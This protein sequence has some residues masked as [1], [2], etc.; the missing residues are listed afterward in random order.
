MIEIRELGDQED[1]GDDEAERETGSFT[2]A[3]MDE[4]EGERNE[5]EGERGKGNRIAPVELQQD[6]AVPERA[7]G[8]RPPARDLLDAVQLGAQL[9]DGLLLDRLVP[10]ARRRVAPWR[11][12][13][14]ER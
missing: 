11:E 5:A 14:A 9:G 12:D 8:V 4:A 3:L 1:D 7:P 10:S 6:Q 13:L 2:A